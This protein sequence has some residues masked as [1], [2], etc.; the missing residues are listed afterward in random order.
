MKDKLKKHLM[1]EASQRIKSINKPTHISNAQ[2]K[3]DLL[4][5]AEAK[6][7]KEG[8]AWNTNYG[9][10]HTATWNL[11]WEYPEVGSK[12]LAIKQD[13]EQNFQPYQKAEMSYE[14]KQRRYPLQG[15]MYVLDG[16]SVPNQD[17]ESEALPNE[18]L[19][20]LVMRFKYNRTIKPRFYEPEE[21]ESAAKNPLNIAN[22]ATSELTQI[23]RSNNIDFDVDAFIDD[24]EQNSIP[25][26][27]YYHPSQ[28][29][30]QGGGGITNEIL[31]NF[32]AN[33]YR[34]YARSS[35]DRMGSP[36]ANGVNTAKFFMNHAQKVVDTRHGGPPLQ[37]TKQNRSGRKFSNWQASDLHYDSYLLRAIANKIQQGYALN[38][39]ALKQQIQQKYELDIRTAR[40][41]GAAQVPYKK[42]YM[43]MTTKIVKAFN[44]GMKPVVLEQTPEK[45]VQINKYVNAL[46]NTRDEQKRKNIIK[47]LNGMAAPSGQYQYHWG[48]QMHAGKVMYRPGLA[49]AGTRKQLTSVSLNTEQLRMLLLSLN[50][51]AWEY[52]K[53]TNNLDDSYKP[54]YDADYG[55]WSVPAQEKYNTG[56]N[57][58]FIPYF[59]VQFSANGLDSDPK[60]NGSDKMLVIPTI[61]KL[62]DYGDNKGKPLYDRDTGNMGRNHLVKNWNK[63]VVRQTPDGK[64]ER[65]QEPA[66][67]GVI[68]RWGEK[69][70]RAIQ[71]LASS[72][73]ESPISGN[74][75]PTVADVASNVIMRNRTNA[76]T[77][78]E[79]IIGK[80][81]DNFNAVNRDVLSHSQSSALEEYY[82][83]APKLEDSFENRSIFRELSH[84]IPEDFNAQRRLVKG[85]KSICQSFTSGHL[86]KPFARRRTR[87]KEEMTQYLNDM[88]DIVGNNLPSNEYLGVIRSYQEDGNWGRVAKFIS[89]R[90]QDKTKYTDEWTMIDPDGYGLYQRY[91]Y[92]LA[93]MMDLVSCVMHASCGEKISRQSQGMN[94][95]IHDQIFARHYSTSSG[96][97]NGGQVML[98]I[99]YAYNAGEVVSNPNDPNLTPEEQLE[100]LTVQ[101][102]LN[103]ERA[104]RHDAYKIVKEQACPTCKVRFRRGRCP[105]CNNVQQGMN[106]Y[107]KS[108]FHERL[109]QRTGV[110]RGQEVLLGEH[111]PLPKGVT[112]SPDETE[113][114][115][116]LEDNPTGTRVRTVK[117]IEQLE[118]FIGE[119]GSTDGM[120]QG[121]YR[122]SNWA[123]IVDQ[124]LNRFPSLQSQLGVLITPIN[125]RFD[126][127][128]L[129][130][131]RAI[132]AVRQRLEQKPPPELSGKRTGQKTTFE[133]ILEQANGD[134]SVM[135]T[136]ELDK[137]AKQ[138][139]QRLEQE[140]NADKFGREKMEVPGEPGMIGSPTIE[141]SDEID[142]ADGT[143]AP[144]A[145]DTTEMVS[146]PGAQ[147]PQPTEPVLPEMPPDQPQAPPVGQAP[148]VLPDAAPPPTPAPAGA[149][150]NKPMPLPGDMDVQ[151]INKNRNKK[152]LVRRSPQKGLVNRSSVI[153]KLQKIANELDS[154]DLTILADKI[155]LILQ[156]ISTGE[157]K[158]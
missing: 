133:I 83:H 2:I 63:V 56:K 141:Q 53:T 45:Q 131:K 129:S 81:G 48:T 74:K 8:M 49:T 125:A 26:N 90:S 156:K 157:F 128:E 121:L 32:I 147:L 50:A 112:P 16:Y 51:N 82:A 64:Q 69:A 151:Y 127:L 111:T 67:S 13:I 4:K 44:Q 1:K 122:S 42:H 10:L 30:K 94:D 130:S 71:F 41:Q 12:A 138:L 140:R 15:G 155:D 158:C 119:A 22:D 20:T 33:Q 89:D 11:E 126:L 3:H 153:N 73:G 124:F 132:D 134:V 79:E 143:T 148:D 31:D 106:T 80:Y 95:P 72:R 86:L 68:A 87:T 92:P 17:D 57:E 116:A 76:E 150:E 102:M 108:S 113:L 93:K 78:Y 62:P 14:G 77:T 75:T 104:R 25:L 27:P 98:G 59:S 109:G 58:F 103:R 5:E 139:E 149:E 9:S 100:A 110:I 39:E 35:D 145:E 85:L 137:E 120:I 52:L 99:H 24:L 61:R 60:G 105:K 46:G 21:G 152:S 6:L 43:D 18:P 146:P 96:K 36:A 97:G 144:R 118:Y 7:R 70:Q 54:Q 154:R 47:I 88:M 55:D 136:H 135:S 117:V 38:I 34:K 123:D 29:R 40:V 114:S 84:G 115:Q 19:A 28:L 107:R 101:N 91:G 66:L 65:I 142:E 37:F 23:L